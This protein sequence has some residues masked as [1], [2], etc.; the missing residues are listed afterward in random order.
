MRSGSG[1]LQ[2]MLNGAE[3]AGFFG[4]RGKEGNQTRHAIP[5]THS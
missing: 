5:V 3:A 2:S 4:C 1:N